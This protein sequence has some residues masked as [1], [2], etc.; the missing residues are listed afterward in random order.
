MFSAADHVYMAQALALARRGLYST[1]PNPR[2]GCVLV[3]DG[4]VVGQGWH[5]RAGEPHAEV[6]AL[7]EAGDRAS[8]ATAY[9]TLEP[10][11]HH[12]RTPPC[13]AALIAAG[14]ARVVVAM[15]DPN[16]KV[17]GQ[18]LAQL[19]QAG[20]EVACGLMRLEAEALNPGFI[21]RMRLGLP[22]V[23][24]KLAVSLDGRT[25]MANGESKWI[26]GAAARQDVQRWRAQS[27]AVMTGI[28]TVLADD[29][30][31]TVR[32]DQWTD[33]ERPAVAALGQPMR[34]VLDRLLRT[35]I[36]AAML[37]QSG[38]TRIYT[39]LHTE[40][41]CAALTAA[42]AEVVAL[43]AVDLNGI[44][45]SLARDGV[46]EVLVEAGATLNGALIDAELVD[47]L[48]IYLA[49]HLMGDQGHGMFHLPGMQDMA[50]RLA[51]DITDLRAVGDD[52]RITAIPNYQR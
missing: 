31:L 14:V 1:H 5:Q 51:L 2:V 15:E 11:C 48:I 47:E 18:G 9:V 27:S 23:R 49:P 52:W 32:P 20:I 4:V 26:T 46:N 21:K 24:C 30:L 43:D 40:E 8:A 45:K 19:R 10:C 37:R 16:P 35:P 33:A 7:R 28:G 34:V 25:A 42:G 22:Y 36:D 13:S 29:P 50:Q 17:A 6:Y 41:R 38:R 39:M 44:M 12:G 3:R